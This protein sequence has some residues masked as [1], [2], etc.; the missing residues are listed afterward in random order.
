[1]EGH[2]DKKSCLVI[3]SRE[4]LEPPTSKTT[5]LQPGSLPIRIS[6]LKFKEPGKSFVARQVKH[7]YK[8]PKEVSNFFLG[9]FNSAL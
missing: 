2:K 5:G 9:N 6:T 4:G 3:L 7:S 8:H 1:M